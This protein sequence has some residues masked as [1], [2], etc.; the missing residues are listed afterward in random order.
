MRPPFVI[1]G[2]GNPWRGDDG[3]GWA[4]ID[5]LEISQGETAEAGARALELVRADGEA[6]RL[7]EWWDGRSLAVVVD[8]VGGGA[9]AGTIVELDHA[10]LA[11]ADP[12]LGSHSLGVA[13][14]AAL[15]ATLGR[16]PDRLVF[17]GVAGRVFG[18][19]EP[20]S[21]EVVAA[22]PRVVQ[23][24]GTLIAKATTCA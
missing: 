23:R 17:I 22:V 15:A 11:S 10:D 16:V 19:G 14:A 2:V 6:A 5:A 7:I 8:A 13:D 3:V 18:Q 24:I 4:V 21:P 12:S 1:V 9:P 20:L